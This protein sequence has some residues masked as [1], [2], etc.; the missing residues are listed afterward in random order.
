[1]TVKMTFARPPLRAQE[2]PLTFPETDVSL[3]TSMVPEETALL[4]SRGFVFPSSAA[5]VAEA[6]RNRKRIDRIASLLLVFIL[7]SS[8]ERLGGSFADAV[9]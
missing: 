4:L 2:T 9:L 3:I 6:V 7:F 8:K 1:L 5:K